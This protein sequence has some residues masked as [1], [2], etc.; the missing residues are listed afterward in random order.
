MKPNRRQLLTAGFGALGAAA[1][2]RSLTS[3]AIAGLPHDRYYIF[4]YFPAAWDVLM[5]LDPKAEA[6]LSDS[7]LYTGG[8][9]RS[10]LREADVDDSDLMADYGLGFDAAP[11]ADGLVTTCMH[12]LLQ[13][14]GA[15]GV[16]NGLSDVGMAVVR[17]MS[18]DTLTHEVGRRRFITGQPPSGQFARGSSMATVMAALT[19]TA[20]PIPNIAIRSETYNV[21]QPSYATALGVQNADDLLRALRPADLAIAP[22]ERERVQALLDEFS[23]CVMSRRSSS[24]TA[25]RDAR[26][27]AAGVVENGLDDAFDI[28]ANTAEMTQL[29]DRFQITGNS[30]N[31]VEAR[32]ALAAQAIATRTSRV[33]SYQAS[34]GL[35]TH[36]DN[37]ADDQFANQYIGF[38]GLAAICEHLAGVVNPSSGLSMLEHTT[39]LAFSDF[40]RTPL[41]N[42]NDGR[43]HWLMNSCLLLGKG[44][45]TGIHGESSNEG[46]APTLR[47]IGG[48][49]EYVKPEHIHQALLHDIGMPPDTV[50]LRVGPYLDILTN[51]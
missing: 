48:V 42:G 40:A 47:D 38:R 33:V 50:D 41:F 30:R 7:E 4:A 35:D 44:I 31:T 12:P 10:L 34:S 51:P 29:R 36:F 13:A 14:F 37:W 3:L 15:G 18:M 45:Q 8:I 20:E 16:A 17:G 19:A 21:D 22:E 2:G 28:F 11:F 32:A 5:S 49:Q 43:D 1:L 6:S 9:E 39:I 26:L 23:D 24:A 27:A 25:A 46:M